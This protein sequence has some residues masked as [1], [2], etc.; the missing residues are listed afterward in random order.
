ME[1]AS[2]A[3]DTPDIVQVFALASWVE[4]GY[5]IPCFD[6]VS[7]AEH[8]NTLVDNDSERSSLSKYSTLN[9]SKFEPASIVEQWT[10]LIYEITK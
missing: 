8:I 7:M 10:N 2:G 5:I 1:L 3:E 9:S 6:V 4:N